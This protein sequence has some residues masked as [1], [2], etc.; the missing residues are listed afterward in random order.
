MKKL[1]LFFLIILV[2]C[3]N[4]GILNQS[5]TISEIPILSI[6]ISEDNLSELQ[7]SRV[8]NYYAPAR[9]YFDGN[10]FAG[11]IRPAG[12]GARYHPKWSYTV[13]IEKPDVYELKKFNLNSQATDPSFIKTTLAK[14]IFNQLDFPVFKSAYASVK[15]NFQDEGLYLILERIEQEFFDNRNLDVYELIKVVKGA[16][17]TFEEG[18]TLKYNFEKKIPDDEN[19][20]NFAEMIYAL[21][22]VNISNNHNAISKYI[23][24]SNYLKYHATSSV[25]NNGDSF[26]NNF[27]M[28]KET[29]QSPY[30]VIP[31]DFDNAFDLNESIGIAGENHIKEVIWESDTLRYEYFKNIKYILDNIYTQANLFPIIDKTAVEIEESYNIDPYLGYGR[32]NLEEEINKLKNH[33]VERRSF[34][35]NELERHLK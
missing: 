15:I 18:N 23:D 6:S 9:F 2:S 20:S 31:W 11:K 24:M 35:L 10:E 13:D 32:F 8:I 4:D 12:S 26:V 21:D 22:T 27:F 7:R 33:I 5:E 19:Y 34:L 30:K 1:A 25:I 17:F 14:Y 16:K 28:Y 29:A 3:D